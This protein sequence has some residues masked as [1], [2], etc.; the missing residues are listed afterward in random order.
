M[1]ETLT[2]GARRILDAAGELF[3]QRGLHAVGVDTIAATA[4][5]TKKT[6]YDRFGSKDALVIAYLRERD[7]Q[8]HSLLDERL[9]RPSAQPAERVLIVFDAAAEWM[10]SR[11]ARGCSAINAR[12]EIPDEGHPIAIEVHRQKTWLLELLRSLAEEA[13]VDDPG[14]LAQMLLLLLDGAFASTGIHAMP[15]PFV[16]AR[17]AAAML[18]AAA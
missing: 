11:G 5:V 16:A 13:R 18:V 2:P 17:Q 3:Y 9:S 12:A 14:R 1:A 15:A 7:A 8:W 6:L 10:A 4:G